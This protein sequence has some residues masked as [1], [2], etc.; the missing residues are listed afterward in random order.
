MFGP[1][2]QALL[3]QAAQPAI[4]RIQHDRER[5]QEVRISRILTHMELH[6]YQIQ[7]REQLL[8]ELDIRDRNVATVFAAK[9]GEPL[10]VYLR[11]RRL[12]TAARLLTSAEPNIAQIHAALPF[13]YSWVTQ[14]RHQVK[15]AFVN[16]CKKIGYKPDPNNNRLLVPEPL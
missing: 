1:R 5:I 2:L 10:M 6:L 8:R 11:N 12:E 14:H 3:D 7:S 16:Y 4:R 15:V 9:T 13:G